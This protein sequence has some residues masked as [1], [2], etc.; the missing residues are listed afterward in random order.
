MQK[1]R[2]PLI[3]SISIANQ[4]AGGNR[5]LADSL[6]PSVL[7]RVERDVV[8]QAGVKYSMIFEGVNDIGVAATDAATQQAI[9]DAVIAAYK[10]VIARVHAVGIPI[11]GATITPFCAPPANASIQPYSDAT[12]EKT[13]Q[14]V[15]NWIRTSGRFDAVIDFDKIVRSPTNGSILADKYNSGDFLHPNV[16]GYA[17]IAAQFP[18]SLFE[19]FEG[20]VAGFI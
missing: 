2:N 14:R 12:R 7:S 16:A 4:A 6:G 15:N 10:Q 18:L 19:R 13:R 20:G 1:T 5:I 9:G 17:A 11:F 3:T 8:A